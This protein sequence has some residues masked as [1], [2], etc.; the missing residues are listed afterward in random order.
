[1]V[2]FVVRPVIR[3]NHAS[4]Y[5]EMELDLDVDADLLAV[6]LGSVHEEFLE[7]D[8]LPRTAYW[9]SWRLA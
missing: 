8:C 3:S 5:S 9:G 1:V 2:V 6:E 7:D 4:G